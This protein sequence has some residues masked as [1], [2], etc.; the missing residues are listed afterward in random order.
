MSAALYTV[1]RLD[2]ERED[3]ST[4][5]W[6]WQH[7]IPLA[8]ELVQGT[9][10]FSF[11]SAQV[12]DLKQL[13]FYSLNCLLF[14]VKKEPFWSANCAHWMVSWRCCCLS[15]QTWFSLLPQIFDLYSEHVDFTYAGVK[16]CLSM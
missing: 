12:F 8:I 11:S 13:V 6:N 3:A 14:S 5:R 1:N 4:M 16:N 10:S 2:D 15:G 7:L 9:E